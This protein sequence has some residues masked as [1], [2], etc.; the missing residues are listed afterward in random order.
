[1][2]TL[3]KCNA[4]YLHI[5]KTGGTFLKNLFEKMNL[6]EFGFSRDHADMERVVN[7]SNHY[8]GNYLLRSIQLKRNLETHIQQCYKFTFVRNPFDWY[9]SYWRFMEDLKWKPFTNIPARTRFGFPQ[10]T[11][12]PFKP[13]EKY[14]HSNF[15]I[16]IENIIKHEPGFL[17]NMYNGFTSPEHIDFVG[18]QENLM[19]DILT[20]FRQLKIPYDPNLINLNYKINESKASRPSWDKDNKNLLFKLEEETFKKYGYENH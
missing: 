5:P 10:D 4:I 8:P 7:I 16:F 3:L 19:E 17:T 2:A 18:K 1:M 6:V 11:W 13:I 20:I 15:N 14:G 12:H 9:E